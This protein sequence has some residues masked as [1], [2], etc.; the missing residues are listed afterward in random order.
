MENQRT[1]KK[2]ATG[3][4]RILITALLIAVVALLLFFA[5]RLFILN[6]PAEKT[7]ADKAGASPINQPVIAQNEVGPDEILFK[8][9]GEPVPMSVYC[10]YLYDS[11]LRLEKMFM[12]N[13]LSFSTDMGEGMTLGQYVIKNSVDGVKFS[14][15]LKKLAAELKLDTS[16]SA[17]EVDKYLASTIK[18]AFNGDEKSFRDQLALMGTTLE[19]F[20]TI[21]ISQRLGDQV[22]EHY[23][24][25]SGTLPVNPSDYYDQFITASDILL[26]TV[27]DEIDSLT[28]ER[29][30]TPLSDEVIAQKRLLAEAI[31]ERLKAGEDFYALLGEYGE[32]PGIMK[33]NNPQQQYTFQRNEKVYDFSSAASSIEVGKYSDIVE[34]PHG[35][36]I[37]LRLP[38]DTARVAEV[39]ETK[40]FRSGLFNMMLDDTSKNYT[41]ESYPLFTTA[42]LETWYKEYKAKNY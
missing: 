16:Q 2:Q 8:I 29:K 41:F 21:L 34:T 23:Y 13:E 30:Q 7:G 4:R 33:E 1:N 32:D 37:I 38:L 5:V 24:G 22:F 12:T 20:R 26:F 36:Y 19:S 10:Y 27:K 18:D 40:A 11:F 28:G 3:K 6:N 39:V 35:Y 31:L 15:A 17:A 9:D 42:S 25:E 14:I